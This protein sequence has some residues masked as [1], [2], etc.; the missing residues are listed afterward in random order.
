MRRMGKQ[1]WKLREHGEYGWECRKSGWEWGEFGEWGWQWGEKGGNEG[2]IHTNINFQVS[3]D[4]HTRSQNT[5][6]PPQRERREQ[7]NSVH[8]FLW[9]TN[10]DSQGTKKTNKKVILYSSDCSS[11]YPAMS[12]LRTSTDS[13]KNITEFMGWKNGFFYG[14]S[15]FL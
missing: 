14:S 1:R 9:R 8:R 5:T 2:S 6:E 13:G 10:S 15:N 11:I 4:R 7:E 12:F 3:R